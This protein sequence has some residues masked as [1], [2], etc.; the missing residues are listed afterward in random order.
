M[1]RVALID[2]DIIIYEWASI[3]EKTIPWPFVNEDEEP[4]ILY[5][6]HAHLDEA[7]AQTLSS[8]ERLTARVKADSFIAVVTKSSEN[9]RHAVYPAYKSNRKAGIKPM[10]V[11]VLRG[12]IAEQPWGR[13]MPP[14]EGD[15][16]LG[17]LQ[18][19]PG[20][21]DTIII[22]TDKDM[23][24]IPGKHYNPGKDVI[25]NVTQ[26]MANSYHLRQALTGDVTDGYPGCTG[27]GAKTV[28]GLVPESVEDAEVLPLWNDV[29][30]PTFVKKGFTE[31]FALSQARVAR[32]CRACDFDPK[33]KEVIL[34]NPM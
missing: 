17:I 33:K 29:I 10:L 1:T 25:F 12:L 2:A 19:K 28:L 26:G 4:D 34:W 27:I 5:T 3:C 16:V 22:S 31:E 18:T 8:F 20:A 15:D 13:M 24:T 9:W 6:R 23:Q 11:D 30:V 21:G 7:W 14:L 32:I